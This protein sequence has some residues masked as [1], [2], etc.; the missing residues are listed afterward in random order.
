MRTIYVVQLDC[1]LNGQITHSE[2]VKAFGSEADALAYL[3]K[4]EV[5]YE[6]NGFNNIGE[7]K[8]TNERD[9]VRATVTFEPD[10]TEPE[11]KTADKLSVLRLSLQE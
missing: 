9:K 8:A 2:P 3:H 7:G 4:R 11:E 5:S 10:V 6:Q 1:L